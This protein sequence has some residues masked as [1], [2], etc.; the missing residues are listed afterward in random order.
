MRYSGNSYLACP[1]CTGGYH[2]FG[3]NPPEAFR[4]SHG[5]KSPSVIPP[6]IRSD[7]VYLHHYL[8]ADA[9][10]RLA[11]MPD[12]TAAHTLELIERSDSTYWS[13]HARGPSSGSFVG[14]RLPP[15]VHAADQADRARAQAERERQEQERAARQKRAAAQQAKRREDPPS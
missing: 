1:Q 12:A 14:A 5:I 3:L 13:R 11:Q 8:G 6:R 15:M 10:H 2:A 7:G 9:S 4:G